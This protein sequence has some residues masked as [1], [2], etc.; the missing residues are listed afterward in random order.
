M[1]LTLDWDDIDFD[2]FIRRLRILRHYYPVN[3]VITEQSAGRKGYHVMVY[4]ACKSFTDLFTTRK[5]FWDDKKR[6]AIDIQRYRK[7]IPISAFFT[8]KRGKYVREY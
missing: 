7:G 4:N 5:R 8:Q 1:R 2:E 6:L 3:R